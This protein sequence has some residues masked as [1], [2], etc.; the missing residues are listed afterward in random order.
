MMYIH[1]S[2][3][4]RE[5]SNTV[6][7]QNWFLALKVV[8]GLKPGVYGLLYHSPNGSD[9]EFLEYLEQSW[10][11]N[12]LDDNQLNLIAGDFNINWENQRDSDN[13]RNVTQYYNL[14]QKV[15]DVTR[16]T[17]FTATMIDLIFCNEDAIQVVIEKDSKISDHETLRINL[18]DKS[19]PLEDFL[20]I[21]CWKNYSKNALL[22]L[23][24]SKLP[25][26]SARILNEKADILATVLKESVNQ[27][28]VVKISKKW[29][30]L[31]LKKIES[32]KR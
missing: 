5:I 20:T 26:D 25:N 24:R 1:D 22:S 28:V 2:V 3:K 6:V 21:N 7:G 30:T 12:I 8:K 29:Y 23:L 11:D 14:E 18:N 17:R 13:L 31:E 9:Y 27:L 16:Q 4:F 10:L 32:F 15:K 19:E